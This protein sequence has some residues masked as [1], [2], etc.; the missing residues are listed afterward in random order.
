MRFEKLNKKRY[1]LYLGRKTWSDLFV[2]A[3]NAKRTAYTYR[4]ISDTQTTSQIAKITLPDGTEY[5]YEYDVM[6]NITHIQHILSI[7]QPK[8]A[9]TR[10]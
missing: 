6:G 9:Y 1:I 10:G 4:D 2:A 5:R 7:R 8:S 3:T